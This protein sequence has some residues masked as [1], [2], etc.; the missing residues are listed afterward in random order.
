MKEFTVKLCQMAAAVNSDNAGGK[1]GHMHLIL[2]E[3]E[4]RIATKNT[5]ATVGLLKN[6]PDV[7]PKFQLLKKD[8]LTKYK[9]LQ[10]E[11][12]T[13][14]KITAYLTQEGEMSKELVCRMVASI[15][16]EYI[17]K[18]DNE[19]TG[20]NNKTPKSILAHLA[21]EYCKATVANQLKADGE[22]AKPWN[23]VTNLGT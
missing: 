11:A 23:Q 22:F 17:K 2:K 5:T 13:R 6:P 21:T 7:N 8:E 12:E 15:E 20:Y 3:K 10:L 14:Q 18:L 16:M 4:Y 1:F 9:V 19:Y